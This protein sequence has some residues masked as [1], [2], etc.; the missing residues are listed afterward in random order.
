M[1]ERSGPK[2]P[3]DK[4]PAKGEFGLT[5]VR[6]DKVKDDLAT[7]VGFSTKTLHAACRRTNRKKLSIPNS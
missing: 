2:R 4:R 5:A 7:P 6:L 1:A 3:A